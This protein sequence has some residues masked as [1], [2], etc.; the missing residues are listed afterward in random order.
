MEKDKIEQFY[1]QGGGEKLIE[2]NCFVPEIEEYLSK[3]RQVIRDIFKGH[4][5]SGMLE[6]GCMNGRNL[7]IAKE[8]GIEY[9]GI[10]LVERFI[11]EANKKIGNLEINARAIKCDVGNL[12]K[13]G[14]MLSKSFLVV[15]PFNSFGNIDEPQRALN[16]VSKEGLDS[17]ILTYGTDS[18]TTRVRRNYL[19]NS[20]LGKLQEI[21]TPKGVVFTSVG[22]LCS[23]AYSSDEFARMGSLAGY[24]KPSEEKFSKIGKSYHF[25]KFLD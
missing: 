17:L 7:N 23:Y 15:F 13:I 12:H 11:E 18:M 9:I 22:G 16:A 8:L 19:E 2:S 1:D 14:Y 10:D 25:R 21:I 5:Y 3:E 24:K 20:E 4:N 6:V